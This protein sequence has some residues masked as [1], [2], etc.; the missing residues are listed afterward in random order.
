MNPTIESKNMKTSYPVDRRVSVWVGNFQ[1]EDDF[2]KAIDI[3]VVPRLALSTHI[4]SICE[5]GF[6]PK[7]VSIRRLIEGFSGGNTFVDQATAKAVARGIRMA[8][9]ALVC[10]YVTCEDAPERWGPFDFLGSFVGQDVT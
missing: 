4:E 9:A 2:D 8:N 7:P 3:E 5:I 10:Y 1:T 6:K